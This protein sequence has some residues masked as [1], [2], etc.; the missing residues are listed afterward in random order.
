MKQNEWKFIPHF[1]NF[2]FH[3]FRLVFHRLRVCSRLINQTQA[4]IKRNLRGRREEYW[5]QRQWKRK[6]EVESEGFYFGDKWSPQKVV[7]HPVFPFLSPRNHI[8]RNRKPEYGTKMA[9][10]HVFYPKFLKI[11]PSN[12][13]G[14]SVF[15]SLNLWVYWTVRSLPVP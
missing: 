15:C 9:H 5:Y 6:K 4:Q 11:L 7:C 13:P 14:S 12:D 3:H 8:L 2:C 1:L 10:L